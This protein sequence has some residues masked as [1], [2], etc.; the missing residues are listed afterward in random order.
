MGTALCCVV[1]QLVGCALG[2]CQWQQSNFSMS[3]SESCLEPI[4]DVCDQ[5][6][7][8]LQNNCSDALVVDTTSAPPG[9]AAQTIAPGARAELMA[10]AFQVSTGHFRVPATLGATPI[11][12]SWDVESD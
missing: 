12:L 5:S 10:G 1:G 7:I 8:K 3:P 9:T 2:G 6:S 4:F 11:V